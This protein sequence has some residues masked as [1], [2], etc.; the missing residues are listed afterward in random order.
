MKMLHP[1]KNTG[2]LLHSYFHIK[3]FPQ[4]VPKVA[5][6]VWSGFY[7]KINLPTFVFLCT[8][9]C[10]ERRPCVTNDVHVLRTTSMCYERR[11]CCTNDVHV[12]RT[13]SMLYERRPGCTNDVQVVRTTSML[14]ERRPCCTND[15]HVVRTTTTLQG[16]RQLC[17]KFMYDPMKS[18][19]RLSPVCMAPWN[20]LR[21]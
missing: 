18:P 10:Y 5:A 8:K 21:L 7:I 17:Q 20:F 11:P 4:S 15:V 16:Q 14:Y 1:R 13:T 12:L 3:H 2:V 6:K 9:L 19:E